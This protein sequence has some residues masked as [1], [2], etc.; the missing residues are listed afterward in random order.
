MAAQAVCGIVFLDKP[1][2]WTSRRAVNEVARIFSVPGEKRIK[3]GHAGT[4]DPLATGMLPVLLGDATRFADLGLNAEKSYRVS[5][6]LSYQ[7]DTLDREGEITARFDARVSPAQLQSAL[8]EFRGAIEQ[9]PPQYSAIRID[10]KRA[11]D[12]ARRGE[13]VEMG[14]RPVTVHRLDL[15][16]F[17]FPLVTLQVSCSKGAYIRALARDIGAKLG[18]GGCVT[19][20]RRL[21]TGGWPE[22]MMVTPDELAE[23]SQACLLPLAQWLRDL[24]RQTLSIEDGRRFLQGQRIQLHETSADAAEEH[25]AVFSRDILLGTGLLKPGLRHMVLHP[26]KIMPSAQKRLL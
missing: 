1:S 22:A 4:L 17:D 7:S 11:H 20:L 10:G 14:A 26:A 5:F 23:E 13:H 6:D 24:G 16:A 19:D 18:A 12:L 2:G 9:V 21:S 15:L 3:A 25:V 8:A